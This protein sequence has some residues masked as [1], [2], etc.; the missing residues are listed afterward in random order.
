MRKKIGKVAD[1]STA[2]RQR[3]RLAIRKKVSGTSERPRIVA[4]KSNK[5]LTVQVIDDVAGKTLFSV[6]TYGKNAVAG[7]KPNKDGAKA[8]GTKVAE[9]LKGQKIETAVFDRAGYRYHGVIAELVGAVRE[10]GIR[11]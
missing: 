6:Q 3:R 9:Q 7:A 5:H 1:V 10:N 4:Q 11:V 2:R 8:V